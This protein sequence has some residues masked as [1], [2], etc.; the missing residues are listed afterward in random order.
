MKTVAIIPAY[1]EE[2]T[3]SS[4]VRSVL[5]QVNEVIVVDDGST[6]GTV[7]RSQ[8]DRVVIVSHPINCGL[9]AALATGI[10]VARERAADFAVTIDADGQLFA[11]DIRTVLAPLVSGACDVVIGS[12]FLNND[13]SIPF[14]RKC[15]NRLGNLLTWWLFGI[16]TTDSQSGIRGFNRAGLFFIDL[17]CARMEVSS[18]FFA[19]IQAKKLRW[20]EVPI[21]VQYTPYSL[22]KGQGFRRGVVTA[23][24]LVLRRMYHS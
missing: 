16:W 22:S 10:A 24:R 8:H 15:Y 12:R 21:R 20:E 14:L 3:I 4:V 6:D 5:S 11:A 7:A 17:R 9:G 13:S 2:R 18:E 23:I 19:E 1:N